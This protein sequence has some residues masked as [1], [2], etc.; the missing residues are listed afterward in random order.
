[1]SESSSAPEECKSNLPPPVEIAKIAAALRDRTLDK[2]AAIEEAIAF[3]LAAKVRYEQLAALPVHQIASELEDSSFLDRLFETKKGPKL[4]LYPDGAKLDP[5][6]RSQYFSAGLDPVRKYLLKQAKNLHWNN[7]RT[8]LE[9][10]KL[11]YLD[12]AYT[13][14]KEYAEEIRSIDRQN[15]KRVESGVPIES[16]Y[17]ERRLNGPVIFNRFMDR[18]ATREDIAIPKDLRRMTLSADQGAS[19]IGS[20]RSLFSMTWFVDD[21]T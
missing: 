11:F 17:N 5:E 12:R 18:C 13:N 20:S 16:L 3:Y 10:I 1:M 21:W 9:A 19:S 2:E 15:K 14:N 7:S 4:R 8:V 6:T